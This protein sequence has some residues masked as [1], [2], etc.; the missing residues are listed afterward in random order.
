MSSDI[1]EIKEGIIAYD[2]R[3]AECMMM[4]H[5]KMKQFFIIF[6][7]SRILFIFIHITH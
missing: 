3:C 7:G 6:L 1:K 5:S 4:L 2:N